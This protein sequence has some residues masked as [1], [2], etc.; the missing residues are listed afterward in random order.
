[1]VNWLRSKICYYSQYLPRGIY[2][3]KYYGGMVG[4]MAAGEKE[5]KIK[6]FEKKNKRGKDKRRK[7]H[8]KLTI[9]IFPSPPP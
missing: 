9:G 1:M 4:G 7:L 5:L 2:Y 3:A 6:F 8:K